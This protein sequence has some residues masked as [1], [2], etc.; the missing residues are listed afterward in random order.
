MSH[1]TR[2]ELERWWA[3]GRPEERS[4][5]VGHLAA[6]DDCSALYGDILDTLPVEPAA[7][8]E[9]ERLKR[10]GYRAYRPERRAGILARRPAWA[11]LVLAAGLVAAAFLLPV[12]TRRSAPP[13]DGAVRGTAIQLLSPAGTVRPPVEFRWRS[14]VSAASFRLEV[15]DDSGRTVYT[16]RVAQEHTA[17][18]GA[19]EALL[20]PGREYRWQVVALDEAGEEIIRSE[21]RRFSVAALAR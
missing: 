19:L 15:L 6:C 11:G 16:S 2:D 1:L 7:G 3:A 8:A 4:R 5:I 9:V 21:P 14:P 10:L 12:L 20:E 18:P 13:Q 17:V